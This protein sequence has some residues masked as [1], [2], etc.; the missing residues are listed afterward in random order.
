L[1]AAGTFLMGSHDGDSR[2]QPVH[3]V[4][5]SQPFYLETYAVTQGQWEAVMGANPSE[6]R[7]G[8]NLPVE[9]V[10]WED[11]QELI[12]RLNAQE[13]GTRY[14]LPTEAEWEY[15]CRAGS[16]LAYSFG[17]DP[18]QLDTYGWYSL[19]SGGMTHPVGQRRP[20]AWGLYDM[21]GNVWEWMQDRYGNYAPDPVTDP[22]GPASGSD[23]VIRGGS[24]SRDAGLC[25]S[26]FRYFAEPGGRF[27]YLGFR[28]L[29]TAR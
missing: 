12:R 3:Q 11:A 16:Q 2:E 19:N 26:A 7:G 17:D 9:Q 10:S 27:V 4:T 1:I 6:F 25:R 24:W 18:A 29:R 14:R 5:I 21:H 8:R 20:N 23:R 15:A 13:G 22:Q 28:L